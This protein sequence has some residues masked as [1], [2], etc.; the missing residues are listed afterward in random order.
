M[1]SRKNLT[2]Y[3]ANTEQVTIAVALDGGA[4]NLTG[5]ALEVYIKADATVADTDPSVSKL[6]IGSGI[7]VLDAPSG[8]VRATIPAGVVVG[9]G[10]RWYRLDVVE[11]TVRRTA[12][13]GTLTIK[14]M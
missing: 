6:T 14:D 2:L 13:Y 10:A 11:G 9:P 8:Q 12:V 1:P 5:A 4:Y 7:T 3:E